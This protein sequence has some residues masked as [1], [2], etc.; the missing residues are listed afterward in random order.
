[1]L[2]VPPAVSWCLIT[3]GV[4]IIIYLHITGLKRSSLTNPGKALLVIL[5]R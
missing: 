1:L 3:C 5:H 4:N 2:G